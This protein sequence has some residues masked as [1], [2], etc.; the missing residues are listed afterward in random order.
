M[1]DISGNAKDVRIDTRKG[2][3]RSET[4]LANADAPIIHGEKEATAR[5]RG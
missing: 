1:I 2:E 3:P 4:V 5:V